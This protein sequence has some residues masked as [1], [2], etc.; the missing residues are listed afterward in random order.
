LNTALQRPPQTQQQPRA[1]E[2]AGNAPGTKY[3]L[4]VAVLRRP[5]AVYFTSPVAAWLSK[6]RRG[7]RGSGHVSCMGVHACC[8]AE[9][10]RQ[11]AGRH[12]WRRGRTASRKRALAHHRHHLTGRDNRP[13]RRLLRQPDAAQQGVRPQLGRHQRHARCGGAHECD[14]SRDVADVLPRRSAKAMPPRSEAV[15]RLRRRPASAGCVTE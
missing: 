11:S 2:R 3:T 13:G 6:Q 14:V 5:T 4:A 1:A 7:G 10:R 9:A 12:G 15:D 8:N